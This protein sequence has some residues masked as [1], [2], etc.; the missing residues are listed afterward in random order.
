MIINEQA[1]KILDESPYKNDLAEVITDTSQLMLENGIQATEL[2]WIILINHLNEMIKREKSGEQIMSV[3][4][5]MFSEVSQE[6]L[7]VA[8]AVS[9]KIGALPID[10]MYVL[11]IHFESAKQNEGLKKKKKKK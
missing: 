4:P 5:E 8:K 3:A 11:S 7:A 10:E 6:A 9:D 2:Q 1:Q